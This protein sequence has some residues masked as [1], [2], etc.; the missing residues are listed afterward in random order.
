M[1]FHLI[2][3]NYVPSYI[4]SLTSSMGTGQLY[5]TWELGAE[6]SNLAA[7]VCREGAWFL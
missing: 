5:G 4:C 3:S 1:G 2:L 6:G 7:G